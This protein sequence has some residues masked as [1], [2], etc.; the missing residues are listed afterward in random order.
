MDNGVIKIKR[1]NAV[2]VLRGIAISAILFIHSSNHFLYS[3]M[4]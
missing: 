2:D 3:S 1:I 4:P